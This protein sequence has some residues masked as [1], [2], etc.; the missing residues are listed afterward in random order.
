[1]KAGNASG[2]QKAKKRA[3]VI[4]YK[5]ED[6]LWENNHLGDDTPKNCK[7]HCFSTSECIDH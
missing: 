5:D 7:I 2:L 6:E 3:E 1:M 4:T